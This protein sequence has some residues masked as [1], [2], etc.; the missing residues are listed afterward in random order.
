[1]ASVRQFLGD[2]RAALAAMVSN[3]SAVIYISQALA[4]T[5]SDFRSL[6]KDVRAKKLA[7]FR[8][9]VWTLAASAVA[10]PFSDPSLYNLLVGFASIYVAWKTDELIDSLE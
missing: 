7:R 4:Q 2:T 8:M 1:M 6:P 9:V 3:H 10:M 5:F